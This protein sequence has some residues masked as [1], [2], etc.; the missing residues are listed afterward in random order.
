MVEVSSFGNPVKGTREIIILARRRDLEPIT[1]TKTSIL[2]ECGKM[3][4]SMAME[5]CLKKEIKFIRGDG[6][7]DLRMGSDNLIDKGK[8]SA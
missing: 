7:T 5:V 6:W 4:D 8:H 3:V 2:K 1:T